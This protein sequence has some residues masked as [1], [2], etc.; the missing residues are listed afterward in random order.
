MGRALMIRMS[1]TRRM[2]MGAACALAVL[3]AGAVHA[4]AWKPSKPIEIVVGTSPGGPQDRMGRAVQRI[5]VEKKLIDVPVNVVNKPGAGGTIA[6]TYL[7]SHANDPHY[8]AVNA[9]TTLTNYVMG[10]TT[11]G[12]AD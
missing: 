4:Q 2:M 9:I 7:N 10:K 3:G 8:V 5:I 12:P 1:H 11:L 6:M